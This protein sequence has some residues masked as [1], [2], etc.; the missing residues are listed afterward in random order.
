MV[1]EILTV[2]KKDILFN[3]TLRRVEPIDYDELKQ[4]IS[5]SFILRKI[6][7][8]SN[9]EDMV[10]SGLKKGGWKGLALLSKHKIISYCDYRII[11]NTQAEIGV[12]VTKKEYRGNGYM[13]FLL[14][15]VIKTISNR[16]IKISTTKRNGI[17]S[18]LRS[19]G[20]SVYEMKPDRIDGSISLYYIKKNAT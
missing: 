1:M 19:R 11:D 18:I 14:D 3:Y 13:S 9:L 20:F 8:K 7:W 4:L 17:N 12:C 15:C 5:K 6:Y 10:L 2:G 16:N